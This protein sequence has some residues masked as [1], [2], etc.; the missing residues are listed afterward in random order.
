ME[1]KR[2]AFDKLEEWKNR[3]NG[4]TALLIKGARRVGK[5]WL[6]RQFGKTHYESCLYVD[7]ANMDKDLIEIFE[8]ASH[9]DF[10]FI[11]LQAYFGVQLVRRKSLVIFDEVQ[12]FPK[13]RQLIKYLVADG[14]FDYIETGSL[15]GLR[16]NVENIVIPS[17]EE[18]IELNP[19][20]FE[21]FLWANDELALGDFIRDSFENERALGEALHRKALNL[22]RLYLL[23]GGMPQSV[24]AYLESGELEASE[25]AKRNILELY[26]NDVSK[27][28]KGYEHKV[29]AIFDDIPSQL[30]RHEKRFKLSSLTKKAR[31]RD[32]EDSFVW[33]S[34]AKITNL[35][36]N[37]TDPTVGLTLNVDRTT[38]KCYLADTGLLMTQAVNSGTLLK[39]EV[40]KALS[41]GK[42]EINE[43]MILENAVAQMLC[44]SG[45]KL[46]FYSRAANR[47]KKTSAIEIDFLIRRE[48][49]ICPIEVKSSPRVCHASL[50]LFVK[51]FSSRLGTRYVLYTKDLYRD[52]EI[53]YLPAYMAYLL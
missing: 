52:K 47:E 39:E 21:E 25:I 14:R 6:A 36:F 23:I 29:I 42:L 1:L 31:L 26:R 28:A 37:A 2:K 50:D 19:L 24:T 11:R 43:G 12:L 16:Q 51:R 45:H 8:D 9:L 41:Y 22:F 48:K 49:K 7:F 27:F 38:L 5:T 4:K 35:C 34:E 17:E 46:Y 33:L 40:L 20:D 32:Y 10:F 18:S 3:S 53:L 44:A 30:S 13:A 15:I